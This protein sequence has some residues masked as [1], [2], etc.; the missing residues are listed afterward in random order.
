MNG[1]MK[2]K[3]DCQVCF[4]AVQFYIRTR[5]LNPYH[6]EDHAMMIM[7][8]ILFTGVKFCITFA[9]Y[10]MLKINTLIRLVMAEIVQKFTKTFPIALQTLSDSNF[11]RLELGFGYAIGY[12]NLLDLLILIYWICWAG[13]MSGIIFFLPSRFWTRIETRLHSFHD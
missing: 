7:M 5:H 13:A 9:L 8:I 12:R 1:W 4:A 6:R 11:V 10:W 2:T 3:L